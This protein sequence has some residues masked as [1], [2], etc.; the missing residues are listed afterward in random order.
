MPLCECH[1]AMECKSESESEQKRRDHRLRPLPADFWSAAPTGA[2]DKFQGA[3]ARMSAT[4]QYPRTP[5]LQL[6]CEKPHRLVLDQH[7][8]LHP[9]RTWRPNR[10]GTTSQTPRG[11]ASPSNKSLP[12]FKMSPSLAVRPMTTGHVFSSLCSHHQFPR[13]QTLSIHDNRI[14]H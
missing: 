2:A 10:F 14:H 7:H 6:G 8:Q 9:P 3:P 13:P 1:P 4:T 12:K 5:M 11:I